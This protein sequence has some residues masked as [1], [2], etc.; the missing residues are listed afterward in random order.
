MANRF[1]NG[2]VDTFNESKQYIGVRM[3][4]GVPIL[5][6]DWNE[7]ED[8]R[9]Y[10][11]R[12]LRKC[13]VGDGT[14]GAADFQIVPAPAGTDFDFVILPGHCMVDGYDLRNPVP[15]LFSQQGGAPKL[16]ASAVAD[17]F[18]VYVQPQI[19]R[20][21]ST[22]DRDLSNAQDI[23]LETCVRDQLTWT[24]GAVRTPEQAPAGSLP[25][26][27]IQRP[28]G[29]THVDAG[30]IQD[31]RGPLLNLRAL[32]HL[33]D[34]LNSRVS[35]LE[36]KVLDLQRDMVDVR[37]QI[38][39]LF[40]EVH[41]SAV[42]PFFLWGDK[43]TVSI[44]VV[45]LLG[46]PV[47]NCY[48]A[49]STTS[50][51]LSP[52][53][54]VTDANGNATISLIFIETIREPN[55]SEI[56]LL[57]SAVDRV[58]RAALPNPGAIQHAQVLFEPNEISMISKYVHPQ[59]YTN[60]A[61]EIPVAPIVRQPTPIVAHVTVHAKDAE[62]GVVR[63]TGSIQVTWGEWVRDWTLTKLHEVSQASEVGVRIGDLMRTAVQPAAFDTAQVQASVINLYDQVHGD[64]MNLIKSRMFTSPQI[65]DDVLAQTGILGQTIA[66]EASTN[67]GGR[68]QTAIQT[69]FQ[70][71]AQ[72]PAIAVAVKTAIQTAQVAVLQNSSASA[73]AITQ[74]S[75]Q[76]L[77]SSRAG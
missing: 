48:L 39:H 26:A 1:S 53:S 57:K 7:A 28:P 13:Y 36:S 14:P 65:S 33:A 20:V 17:S 68:V 46:D 11:E 29:A 56:G 43:A 8:T 30:M 73:A 70:R 9:R 54:A 3:Q 5:D 71:L 34:S 67:I 37:R 25:L 52:T 59:V 22:V 35:T 63:G 15:T 38:A 41:L 44:R 19:V 2:G 60:L 12:N 10:F 21:D 74:R 16:P 49:C 40:W 76:L 77:N 69:Q 23:N 4:R 55:P 72:D 75:R 66:Q 42:S 61:P 64:T 62:N 27:T 47:V 58:R 31:A 6:R 18:S 51:W 24:V 32:A 50:G 45:D